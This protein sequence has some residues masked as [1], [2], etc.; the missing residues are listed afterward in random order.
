[1]MFLDEQLSSGLWCFGLTWRCTLS[2]AIGLWSVLLFYMTICLVSLIHVLLLPNT[3]RSTATRAARASSSSSD[4]DD[5]KLLVTLVLY[6]FI[7]AAGCLLWVLSNTNGTLVHPIQNWQ[8]QLVGSILLLPCALAFVKIHIDLGDNWYPIPDQPPQ[9]VTHGIFRYARHPMYAV[10]LWSVLG[11]L[12]ATL[13]WVIA[14]CVSG[15]VW[16]TLPRIPIE[17]QILSNVFGVDYLHYQQ[18]V[19][20]ALGRPWGCLGYDY[21]PNN[22]QPGPTM[23]TTTSS[24]RN[25]YHPID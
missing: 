4:N 11:T 5:V 23:R 1:M 16:V 9:L 19:P 22:S 15:I 13:N 17:E 3:T 20:S 24:Q 18:T 6:F 12:L 8:V 10:F 25:Q 14:W 21:Y 2:E 7:F